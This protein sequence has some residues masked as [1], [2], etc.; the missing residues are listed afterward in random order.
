MLSLYCL[1]CRAKSKCENRHM[2]KVYN[3]R[4]KREIGMLKGT[5]TKCGT[6]CNRFVTDNEFNKMLSKK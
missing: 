4:T 5:C 3:T 1:K 6:T 2:S